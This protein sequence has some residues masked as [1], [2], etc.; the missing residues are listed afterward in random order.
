MKV[1]ERRRIMSK[2]VMTELSPG[3]MMGPA[4]QIKLSNL[5]PFSEFVWANTEELDQYLHS[6]HL[7]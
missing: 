7:L 1:G 5:D 3:F 2:T 6:I 4:Y